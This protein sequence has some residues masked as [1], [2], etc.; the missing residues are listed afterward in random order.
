MWL[1]AP[2][3]K[4]EPGQH[5][6]LHEA[7]GLASSGGGSDLRKRKAGRFGGGLRWGCSSKKLEKELVKLRLCKILG[8]KRLK[9]SWLSSAKERSE[10]FLTT[11]GRLADAEPARVTRRG[12]ES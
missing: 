3:K 9:S 5:D 8:G 1:L 10:V 7:E 2:P 12:R 6:L 11:C 4:L